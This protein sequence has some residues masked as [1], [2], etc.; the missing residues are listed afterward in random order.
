MSIV[1]AVIIKDRKIRFVRKHY[2]EIMKILNE[3]KPRA[4]QFLDAGYIIVDLDRKI[5]LNCQDAFSL[6]DLKKNE[7]RKLFSEWRVMDYA[8][9]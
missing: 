5:I 8:K 7:L 4:K 1:N 2:R 3:K 6:L 9:W